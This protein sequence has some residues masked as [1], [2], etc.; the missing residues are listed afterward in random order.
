LRARSPFSMKLIRPDSSFSITRSLNCKRPASACRGPSFRRS[1][2]SDRADDGLPIGNSEWRQRFS[3]IDAGAWLDHA[4]LLSTVALRS[5]RS[6]H[7]SSQGEQRHEFGPFRLQVKERRLSRDRQPNEWSLH[8]HL[9]E[10]QEQRRNSC[11]ACRSKLNCQYRLECVL[12][13]VPAG[14]APAHGSA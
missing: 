3:R 9:E 12:W 14:R 4:S 5:R 8:P 11:P 2:K 6:V 13:A 10:F 1:G 7:N